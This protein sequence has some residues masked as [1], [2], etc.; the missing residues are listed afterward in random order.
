MNELAWI[1]AS[2]GSA[3]RTGSLGAAS[4]HNGEAWQMFLDALAEAGAFL[5]SERVPPGGEGDAEGY[6]HLMVLLA[7]GI[8]E[9]LRSSDPYE[10]VLRPGNVDNVLKWGM[11]CPDA[12]YMGAAVRPDATYRVWGTRGEA[13][14]VAFQLMAG[15]GNVG[16][17]VVEDLALEPDGSF[18]IFLS[19][20]PHEGNWL[21]L[22]DGASSLV[23]RQFFYDWVGE[24]PADLHIEC[25]SRPPAPTRAD[26]VDPAA[27]VARH[28]VALGAFVREST[29]FWWGVEEAGR[30]QG[31][32]AFRPPVVRSDIGGATDN[33]TVWGSWELADDE[34]LIVEMTP[35]PA[36][37]WS[38][39]IGNQWWETIDY[40]GHQSS[41]N[42][43]QAVLDDGVFRAVVAHRDP[44]VAN[45]LDTAGNRRGPAIV[46]WV[47]AESAPVPSATKVRFDELD[48][49]LPPS[50]PRVS[51]AER[52]RALGARRAGVRK[53]FSR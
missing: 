19:A 13:A 37:Y 21:E 41:L 50:T 24:S 28:L 6:R 1:P 26:P 49:E 18:E 29:M 42:G 16:D 35:P 31:V 38:V 32:N 2:V 11:D 22:K 20:Q 23:V 4:L 15:I 40:A 34:A 27:Q 39:A 45:W 43:R 7:L 3:P 36:M 47:R 30:N 48:R 52:E 10:P 25:L 9:A 46:R 51:P 44:G 8:D 53:R 17:V 33:V 12:L 5:R 14:F